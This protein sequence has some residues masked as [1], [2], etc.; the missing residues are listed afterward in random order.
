MGLIAKEKY[1]QRKIDRLLDH[2]KIYYEKGRP[3]DF[4]S[5]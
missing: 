3:I 1:D 2:L 5:S 4:E